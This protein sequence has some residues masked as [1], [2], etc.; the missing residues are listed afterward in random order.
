MKPDNVQKEI[1]QDAV[2]KVKYEK[3]LQKTGE[4]KLERNPSYEM[5]RLELVKMFD[6]NMIDLAMKG[7]KIQK[8]GYG[9]INWGM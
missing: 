1:W 9:R 6:E 7:D 8:E 2:E 5:L 3:G 4:E